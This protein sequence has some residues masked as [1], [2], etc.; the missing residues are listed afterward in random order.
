MVKF[1]VANLFDFP[2]RK[3]RLGWYVEALCAQLL[4]KDEIT[5][6]DISIFWS[7]IKGIK[8]PFAWQ[9]E[10]LNQEA[11]EGLKRLLSENFGYNLERRIY[12]RKS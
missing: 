9:R 12:K 7:E 4:K 6:E 5:H 1:Y 8:L 3:R 10:N 2:R 11:E